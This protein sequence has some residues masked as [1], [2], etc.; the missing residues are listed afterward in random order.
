MAELPLGVHLPKLVIGDL[1]PYPQQAPDDM[2]DVDDPIRITPV[3]ANGLSEG[4]GGVE[5]GEPGHL[6]AL[7]VQ[8]AQLGCAA[9]ASAINRAHEYCEGFPDENVLIVCVEFSSLLYQ[10]EFDNISDL[11]IY[12]L[13]GDAVSACV[14][15]G[16]NNRKGSENTMRIDANTSFLLPDTERYISYDIE[17]NGFHFVLDK[18]VRHAAKRISPVISDFIKEHHVNKNRINYFDLDYIAIH[19]GGPMVMD[20]VARGLSLE[21]EDISH[22]RNS[23]EEHGNVASVV[24]FDVLE[25][26]FEFEAERLSHGAIGLLLGI[27][28]GVTAEF[29]LTTWLSE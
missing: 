20:Q 29:A 25:R 9:G 22:S 13:F 6:F 8:L 15:K 2:G 19:T 24:I 21:E 12:S 14:V 4:H 16:R 1:Q 11:L 5:D 7:L 3:R 10:P 17:D 28:P 23:L 26:T 18:N 27:G